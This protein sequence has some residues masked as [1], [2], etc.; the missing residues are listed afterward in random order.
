MPST[1][2]RAPDL[3]DTKD[4]WI[5]NERDSLLETL[6]LVTGVVINDGEAR[7][8]TGET[9]LL[10][11]GESLLRLGPKFAIV[12]K[13]EHGALLVT[14]DGFFPIP[15]FPAKIVRDPT[16]A[17]DSFAGGLLG[18]LAEQAKHDTQTLRRALVHGTIAASFAIED[19]SLER[20]RN[21]T[22][23]EVNKRVD[24]FVSMLRFD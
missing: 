22:R 8:L 10:A 24:Q 6:R 14:R 12:K 16:G 11:A 7:Q 17:G 21:L 20:V 1:S 18:Y 4:L 15:A 13:G 5:A 3:C 2:S 19:F 23:A 9:N